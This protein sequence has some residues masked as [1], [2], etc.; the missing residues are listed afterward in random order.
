MRR[1]VC[2]IVVCLTCLLS[3]AYPQPPASGVIGRL[4]ERLAATDD[5]VQQLDIIDSLAIMHQNIDST[6][7][8][9]EMEL[10]LAYE[11]RHQEAQGKALRHI[12]WCKYF[13]GD[14]P[15]ASNSLFNAISIF[16]AVDNQ[17]ETARCYSLLGDIMAR[18]GDNTSAD[19]YHERAAKILSAIGDSVQLA[20]LYR[21]MAFSRLQYDMYTTANEYIQKSTLI[22]SLRNDTSAL[23]EDYY[24]RGRIGYR[25][26][27][28]FKNRVA[29]DESRD[30]C[31]KSYKLLTSCNNRQMLYWVTRQMFGVYIEYSHISEG[32]ERSL[33]LDSAKIYLDECDNIVT[34][35]NYNR[36]NFDC[37][38]LRAKYHIM[39]DEVREA[40]LLIDEVENGIKN[41]IYISDQRLSTLYE[42][43]FYYYKRTKDYEKALEYSQKKDELDKRMHASEYMIASTRSQAQIEFDEKMRQ[44]DIEEE[45]KEHRYQTNILIQRIIVGFG[46][47]IIALLL[48]Q[49]RQTKRESKRRHELY[50]TIEQKNKELEQQK[51]E[52]VTQNE[53][54]FEQKTL[55]QNA[56]QQI[57]ASIEYAQRIQC[58]AMPSHEMMQSMFG[59]YLLFFRPLDIVS[60]DFYWIGN[61]GRYKAIAVAD[62]TGH[63]VPGAFMSMLGLSLLNDTVAMLNYT[64]KDI[65]AA[66]IL[67]FLRDNVKR[68]LRQTSDL[69]DNHDG[70]DMS[71]CLIDMQNKQVQY[72]GAY[73]P[74][75][76]A[77][78]GRIMQYAP[79]RMPIG[80]HM[81]E[82][83]SFTNNVIDIEYGDVIYLYTDGITDQF[84]YTNKRC[85]YT[86]RRLRNIL[87]RIASRPFFEQHSEIDH[88]MY[89]WRQPNIMYEETPCEQTD[90]MLLIGIRI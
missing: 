33:M 26:Y 15:V 76:I 57:R 83:K 23:G 86:A 68:A 1:S 60:G 24:Y 37:R 5:E 53:N 73:R 49:F 50:K 11:T 45:E 38:L 10:D 29:L 72:A 75:L 62:C 13:K 17:K 87:Q 34:Q 77:R 2:H 82:K 71:L 47:V 54:L 59:D 88:E 4:M 19:K 42:C 39:R 67:N 51:E 80:I 56:H 40:K 12:G 74:L 7:K 89:A 21:N 32:R 20:V 43:Y 81:N 66:D 46:L 44:R 25:R 65:E 48:I 28:E 90:D 84:G 9:A 70:M 85:K 36:N 16:E 3:A 18:G 61:V 14:L 52:M 58:A 78:D 55:L 41:G 22:D 79:D 6:L 63:G 27:M 31:Q 64:G 30:W 69:A 8:Y 35:L